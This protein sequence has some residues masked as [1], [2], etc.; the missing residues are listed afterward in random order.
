M[1][2]FDPIFQM[3]ETITSCGLLFIRQH[4]RETGKWADTRLGCW[5]IINPLSIEWKIFEEDWIEYEKSLRSKNANGKLAVVRNG[6]EVTGQLRPISG[7]RVCNSEDDTDQHWQSSCQIRCRVVRDFYTLVVQRF[8]CRNDINPKTETRAVMSCSRA[9]TPITQ[10]SKKICCCVDNNV[11]C[12]DN[13]NILIA[14]CYYLKYSWEIFSA[15]YFQRFSCHET[16]LSS[17]VAMS[18]D[19]K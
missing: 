8:F 5:L 12:H 10:L 16:N 13:N 18:P 3:I 4:I 1:K 6:S 11:E 17:C 7:L 14:L 2:V 9:V 15:K 19:A